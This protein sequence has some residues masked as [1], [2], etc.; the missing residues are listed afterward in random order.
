[1]SKPATTHDSRRVPTRSTL[2]LPEWLEAGLLGGLAV[3]VV[4]FVRDSW[5]GEPLHTA[6]VLGTLLLDGAAAARQTT[7]A[8]GAA[9]IYNA[10]H[11]AIWVVLGLLGAQVARRA[12]DDESLRWMPVALMVVVVLGLAGLDAIVRE[13]GLT[14]SYL[15]LGGVTGLIVVA[16]FLGWRHPATFRR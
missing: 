2:V 9:A 10:V 5:L 3:A 12:E 11:F 7:S 4:F 13:T 1:M 8:P 15:W 6:S 14:R 16:G